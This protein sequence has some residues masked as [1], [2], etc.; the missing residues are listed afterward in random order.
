MRLKKC[1]EL[2]DE[3]NY[4]IVNIYPDA[5][6]DSIYPPEL[7]KLDFGKHKEYNVIECDSGKFVL[8]KNFTDMDEFNT[9]LKNKFFK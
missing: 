3:N 9:E 1:H 7:K 4:Y 5:E 8:D 2:T 6:L